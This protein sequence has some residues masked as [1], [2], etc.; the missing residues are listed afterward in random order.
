VLKFEKTHTSC[1]LIPIG[2]IEMKIYVLGLPW[3]KVLFQPT[4]SK[5][6]DLYEDD[7]Q[8]IKIKKGL[9][10][11]FLKIFRMGSQWLKVKWSFK[12]GRN[13]FIGYTIS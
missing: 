5:L 13:F 12:H 7:V 11:F 3:I 1:Q 6:F 4:T 9:H 10:D 2:N 8:Q